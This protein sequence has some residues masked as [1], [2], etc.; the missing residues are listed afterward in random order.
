MPAMPGRQFEPFRAFVPMLAALVAATAALAGPYDT[1]ATDT[2]IRL[3]Q[4]MP[5]SGPASAYSAIGRAEIAYFKML[6]DKG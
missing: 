6:N 5:Y 2:T 4:T 3:G 1:G